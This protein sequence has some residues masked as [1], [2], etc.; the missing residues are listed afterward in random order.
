MTFITIISV[1]FLTFDFDVD[2]YSNNNI[3]SRDYS[4]DSNEWVKNFLI[5]INMSV[6]HEKFA[7]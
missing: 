2:D 1:R 5:L 3:E 6:I 4:I 7:Y